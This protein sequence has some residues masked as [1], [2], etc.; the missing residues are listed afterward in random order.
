MITLKNSAQLQRMREAGRVVAHTLQQVTEAAHP[1]VSLAELDAIGAASIRAAGARPSFLHYHPTFAPSPFPGVLC[2][3]VN[4]VIVH[5]I[6]SAQVL[7]A[8]DVLS[9]DCGA[10]LDG[11][12]GDAAVTLP[13]GT[14]DTAAADLIATTHRALQA[15]INAAVIGCRLGDISHAIQTVGREAGYGIPDGLG[16]HGVGVAMHEDPYLPNTGQ[17]GRGLRLR[18]GLVLAIEPMFL[19]GGQDARRMLADGWAITTGDGSR[20]AHFEHTIAITADG[21]LILTAP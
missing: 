3:S 9:I 6:P 12:H 5:G 13:I 15:G 14:V 17:R 8:G 21:P 4:D 18:E 19:E 7:R 16:G 10:Q 2:L 11:Y 1:G 20:A